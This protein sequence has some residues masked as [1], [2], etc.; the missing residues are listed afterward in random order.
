M[1]MSEV[2]GMLY[3]TTCKTNL[4]LA[5]VIALAENTIFFFSNQSV[6]IQVLSIVTHLYEGPVSVR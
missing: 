3:W 4:D 1:L 6:S 2:Q 5:D